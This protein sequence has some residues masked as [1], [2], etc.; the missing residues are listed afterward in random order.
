MKKVLSVCVVFRA[1]VALLAGALIVGLGA[2][3]AS[4]ASKR[5]EQAAFGSFAAAGAVAVDESGGDVYVVDP[6]SATV[7]RFDAD[8]NPVAF[9]ALNGQNTLNGSDAG[10]DADQTPANSF[11]FD[12][13]SQVAVDA[14]GGATDGTVYVADSNNQ[15][16][17]VFAA[18]GAYQGQLDG[19]GTPQGRWADSG[20]YPCGVAVGADGRVYVSTGMGNQIDRYVPA[21][22]PVVEANYDSQ[23]DAVPFGSCSLAVD[24][25]GAVYAAP[26]IFGASG[27]LVKFAASDFGTSG[28]TGTQIAANA[29]AVAVDPTNDHVIVDE[30]DKATEYDSSGSPVGSSFGQGSL[31]SS[32]GIAITGSSNRVYASDG[33]STQVHLFAPPVTVPDVTIAPATAITDTTATLHATVN[34]DGVAVNDCHFDYSLDTSYDQT[35]PCSPAPGSASSPVAVTADLTGLTAGKTYHLR[36]SATN[37]N[38]TVISDD[39]TLVTTSTPDVETLYAGAVRVSKA[40]LAGQVDPHNQPGTTYH[41]EWGLGTSYGQVTTTTAAGTGEGYT[42]VTADLEGLSPSTEY[43]FRLVASNPAGTVTGVD[44]TFETLP[45][46]TPPQDCPNAAIRAQQRAERLPDCRAYEQVTPREKNSIE[47]ANPDSAGGGPTLGQAAPSGDAVA[48][49]TIGA[50]PGSDGDTRLSFSRSVRTAS[51]W[52]TR[53]LNPPSAPPSFLA[54]GNLL[55]ISRDL[56][57]SFVESEQALAPGAVSGHGNLYV[58]D[59]TS[60]AY[61]LVVSLESA[62][63]L[64]TWEEYVGG[65][66]DFSHVLFQ[67][68]VVLAPGAVAG[69][70]NL[71][72]WSRGSLRFVDVISSDS[73]APSVLV[74]RQ[75]TNGERPLSEDGR[76]VFTIDW[77]GGV[78]PL[79]VSADGGT[80]QPLSRS[81][82][83]GDPSDPQPATFFGASADGAN[84]IFAAGPGQGGLPLSPD[85]HTGATAIDLYRVDTATGSLETITAGLEPTLAVRGVPAISDDA[86]TVYFSTTVSGSVSR[87]YVGSRGVTHLIATL[88]DL[89]A[90]GSTP[91]TT[92][93][94]IASPSGR[95]FVFTSEMAITGTSPSP[96]EGQQYLFDLQT[97]RVECVS[98]PSDGTHAAS[99]ASRIGPRSY[100]DQQTPRFVLDD[101]RVLFET[102]TPLVPEDVNGK[103]DVYQWHHGRVELISSGR[104]AYPASFVDAGADGRDVFIATREQLASGDTDETVDVYDV[105]TDGGFAADAD[106]QLP[107]VGDGCQG[108]A[109]V[110]PERVAPASASSSGAG[111]AEALPRVGSKLVVPKPRTIVGVRGAL[112]VTVSG[113]GRVTAAGQGLSVASRST[114]KAGTLSVVTRLTGRAASQL[115]RRGRLTAKLR[116]TFTPRSGPS[117]SKTVTLTFR[118]ATI[119]KGR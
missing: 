54:A 68:A 23:I 61:E 31:S 77:H 26:T 94:A 79:F 29:T 119:R 83:P 14:S 10:P 4:A 59:N 3:S 43:H 103:V 57:K 84:A 16:V 106:G 35:A 116:I 85:A 15:V 93:G 109:T 56:T 25:A 6:G 114:A 27:P 17:D 12:A 5:F 60:G 53:G 99:G 33:P 24:S 65:S 11:S 95:Y 69:L 1:L 86:E 105:R 7:Q 46:S 45:S 112:K 13:A 38:G 22:S 2:G 90:A 73:V 72:E 52:T 113:A 71:Y 47:V 96:V 30:G 8:G 55:A 48:Y 44:H 80:R 98:C 63:F 36:I 82:R 42:V 58:R 101:G 39:T 67:S 9:S 110:S 21:A 81:H 70:A 107:C 89:T 76:R 102:A 115:R 20:A 50:L 88:T 108:A 75:M 37:A 32:H 49:A 40:V 92:D 62:H 41:F 97:G 118:A 74:A 91:A 104:G 117:A 111:D 34:P 66:S 19:S 78:S 28:P 87:L 64:S 51:G 100:S 18:S